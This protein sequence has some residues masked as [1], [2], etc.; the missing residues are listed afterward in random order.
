MLPTDPGVLLAP[1]RH[2]PGAHAHR[3][4]SAFWFSVVLDMAPVTYPPDNPALAR[5]LHV[6]KEIM[7]PPV[8]EFYQIKVRGRKHP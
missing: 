7:K 8:L 4:H 3:H 2:L 6:F 1:P 5:R